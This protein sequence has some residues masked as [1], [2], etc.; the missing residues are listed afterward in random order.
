MK[1]ILLIAAA[2]LAALAAVAFVADY[3]SLRLGIPVRAQLDSVEV[4][5]LYAVKLKDNKTSYMYDQPTAVPCVNSV[6][7]HYGD[8]PCWYTKRHTTVEVDLDSGP[9]GAWINTP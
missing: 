8:N 1:R 2:S 4:R 3:L 7:P 6:L 9:F 5:H